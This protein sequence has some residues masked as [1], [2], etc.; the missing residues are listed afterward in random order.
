MA[1]TIKIAKDIQSKYGLPE[2]MP[3][4]DFN[5]WLANGGLQLL[6]NDG[7]ISVSGYNIIDN[8]FIESLGIGKK[9]KEY[10]K[11]TVQKLNKMVYGAE[12]SG[13]K[14]GAK[15]ERSNI[16][17]LQDEARAFL[18][19][20][21]IS[22]NKAIE[23]A[24]GKIRNNL[25]FARFLVTVQSQQDAA[26]YFAKAEGV[27]ELLK[28]IA[29]LKKSDKLTA[30]NK[31]FIKNTSFPSAMEVSDLDT[32][33]AILQ[34]FID[35]RN[36]E[37]TFGN[38]NEKLTKFIEKEN[39]YINSYK[40]NIAALKEMLEDLA[41]KEEYKALK[42]E[43]TFKGTGIE[44]FKDY[45]IFWLGLD[46]FLGVQAETEKQ[47]EDISKSKRVA[48]V[49][50]NI[51]T[52]L[53]QFAKE[54]KQAFDLSNTEAMKLDFSILEKGDLSVLSLK[55]LVLLS[56]ILDGIL[57]DGDF[58]GYDN[59]R[60]KLEQSK[61]K[62]GLIEVLK[63]V[64]G[65]IRRLLDISDKSMRPSPTTIESAAFAPI[66]E[67]KL[68]SFMFGMWNAMI[69]QVERLH[70]I[71]MSEFDK[72]M[73]DFGSK[74]F[75]SS[76][77]VETMGFINQWDEGIT[78][79]E[80]KEQFKNDTT[81]YA[82]S[83]KAL[84]DQNIKSLNPKQGITVKV[85]KAKYALQ[86]L[87]RFGIIKDLVFGDKEVTFTVNDNLT[88]D[89]LQGKL[90]PKEQAFYDF[91][92]DSFAKNR[93]AFINGMQIGLGLPFRGV[94]NYFPR[95]S[96]ITLKDDTDANIK[97][98][99]SGFSGVSRTQD[100][101]KARGKATGNYSI[102]L[103]ENFSKGLWQNLLVAYGQQE[104]NDMVNSIYSSQVGIKSLQKDEI[105]T[106]DSISVIMNAVTNQVKRELTY[107]NVSLKSEY[108]LLKQFRNMVSSMYFGFILNHVYQLVKQTVNA[109]IANY[110]LQPKTSELT[111]KILN[112]TNLGEK[113][114]EYTTVVR[115]NFKHLMTPMAK[116]YPFEYLAGAEAGASKFMRFVGEKLKI[117]DI[118]KPV[119]NKVRTAF[120]KEVK[121]EQSLDFGDT[122][123]SK[124]NLL[125]GYIDYLKK[126]NKGITDAE[127]LDK[128]NNEPLDESALAAAETWQRLLNS[129]SAAAQQ[130]KVLSNTGLAQVFY[131]F[132]SF[133]VNT[134]QEF[135]KNMRRLTFNRKY[136]TDE[137]IDQN[138]KA[139]RAYVIQQAAFRLTAAILT[140]MALAALIKGKG[141]D[142]K[143]KIYKYK[144]TI[145]QFVF[146][147]GSDVFLGSAGIIGDIAIGLAS[148]HY[149]NNKKEEYVKEIRETDPFFDPKGTPLDPNKPLS[150]E[151]TIGGSVFAAVELFLKQIEEWGKEAEILEKAGLPTI[152]AL[153]YP[154]LKTI[155]FITASGT[156]R[157][158]VTGLNDLQNKEVDRI[159]ALMGEIKG[160]Y[161]FEF[162]FENKEDLIQLSKTNI[163][164][165]DLAKLSYFE[166]TSAEYGILYVLT[167]EDM[168]SARKNTNIV[169]YGT[170]NPTQDDVLNSLAASK[171]NLNPNASEE[172]R[173][174]LARQQYKEALGRSLKS[175]LKNAKAYPIVAKK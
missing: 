164:P 40:S 19:K 156:G 25:S 5:A 135:L 128:L 77:A 60:S 42:N 133:R 18:D 47:L 30:S 96:D 155:A 90:N 1:C 69:S 64:T 163:S 132:Q 130:G 72:R 105:L 126:T 59:I 149:W 166:Q 116:A 14:T 80:K 62:A 121:T 84:Y 63:D 98:I 152:S 165:K 122:Y 158:I 129:I 104:I 159:G 17:F 153:M 127:I 86:A 71:S 79:D 81:V 92:I 37:S 99:L 73:R 131:M 147:L 118:F 24:I 28:E 161:G 38:I 9:L 68:T 113:L 120:G 43:G 54:L 108:L 4:A 3:E 134:H 114:V 35:K 150:V 51:K 12:E 74:A 137:E 57:Y 76:V 91:L 29:E 174:E 88:H 169:L 162:E 2:E 58:T 145:T 117:G 175:F 66:S 146:G 124:F 123:I 141:D 144:K 10:V 31:K 61:R 70:N 110:I 6:A 111:R 21:K 103:R 160:Q 41:L 170:S 87:E 32:Y 115:R 27:K 100:R 50:Q 22:S 106:P 55:E 102:G 52:T 8:K 140:Q 39:A 45:K 20:N 48:E 172:T 109:L 95:F 23:K 34:E 101:A 107:G 33:A 142:D 56:N 157:D 85:Q 16:N 143:D 148:N 7:K 46:E 119:I 171:V 173:M 65:K 138:A 53:A 167:K 97:T 78:D 26:A 136:L 154:I 125:A 75:E 13:S 82:A 151:P 94:V 93:A 49:T 11:T 89:D 36:G 168:E 83:V 67:G 139:A 112:N 15:E 44:S